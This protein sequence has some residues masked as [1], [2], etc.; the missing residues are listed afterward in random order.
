MASR[1]GG[2][3]RAPSTRHGEAVY[4]DRLSGS[5]F[6]GSHMYWGLIAGGDKRPATGAQPGVTEGEHSPQACKDIADVGR[7]FRSMS[8][9][10]REG[11]QYAVGRSLPA[12]L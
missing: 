3:S 10:P 9:H 12:F 8:G 1:W 5:P 7:E 2:S 11:V 4:T 6:L